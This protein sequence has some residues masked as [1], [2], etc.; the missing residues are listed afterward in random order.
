MLLP[1]LL[2]TLAVAAPGADVD[3]AADDRAI[4]SQLEA[5]TAALAE[6]GKSPLTSQQRL[7]QC[8]LRFMGIRF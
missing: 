4:F 2:A 5:A 6:T 3:H 7:E 8:K 1:L